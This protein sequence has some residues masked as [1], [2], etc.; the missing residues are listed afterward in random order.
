M[1]F[2][3]RLE[4]LFCTHLPSP[5]LVFWCRK[6]SFLC[7][8]Y[9]FAKQNCKHPEWWLRIIIILLLLFLSHYRLANFKIF[10]LFVALFISLSYLYLYPKVV[11]CMLC[12]N[13]YSATAGDTFLIMF[14]VCSACRVIWY[15][16]IS[17]LLKNESIMLLSMVIIACL[18]FCVRKTIDNFMIPA[19]IDM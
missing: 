1:K 19:S 6:M 14:V 16:L 12:I 13:Y 3:I 11:F 18:V 2:N 5:V 7:T 9:C 15:F 4:L 10:I 8:H 17:G